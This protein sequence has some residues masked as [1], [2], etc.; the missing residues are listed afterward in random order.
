[1][2]NKWAYTNIQTGECI[3]VVA[4]SP[5][6]SYVD[7]DSDTNG[8][9]LRDISSA[10]DWATYPSSKYWDAGW[11]DKPAKPDTHYVWT[12]SGWSFDSTGF[13]VEVRN[14]RNAKLLSCDWT[15]L[16]DAPISDADKTAWA[17]YRQQL[18]DV[19][20]NNSSATTMA[21]I[22]WPTEPA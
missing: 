9:I 6:V 16:A 14:D 17:T 19:P 4:V 1:M 21:D 10:S 15:Q 13:W 12:V 11:Q 8:N 5:S 3:G 7:G 20:S 2:S 22:T 18:R